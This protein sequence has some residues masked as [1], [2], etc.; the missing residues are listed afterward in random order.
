MDPDTSA[1]QKPLSTFTPQNDSSKYIR[2]YAKDMARVTNTPAPEPAATAGQ[3]GMDVA[4]NVPAAASEPQM[5]HEMGVSLP[6]VDE[7]PVNVKGEPASPK[8]FA[9]ERLELTEAD[10]DGIFK[11]KEEPAAPPEP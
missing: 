11:G 2:T 10:S 6:Q 1:P 5:V 4:A 9:G 3:A 8:E 7:S